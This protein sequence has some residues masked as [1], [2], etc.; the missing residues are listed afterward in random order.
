MRNGIG[1]GLWYGGKSLLEAEDNRQNSPTSTATLFSSLQ[2]HKPIHT[3]HQTKLKPKARSKKSKILK[4]LSTI[5]PK[6]TVPM[7]PILRVLFILFL[8]WGFK[9]RKMTRSTLPEYPA[10]IYNPAAASIASFGM[11]HMF[12]IDE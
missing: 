3:S 4:K 10:S 2:Q 11:Y 8:A 6:S 9:Q 1:R 12:D 5:V 7:V